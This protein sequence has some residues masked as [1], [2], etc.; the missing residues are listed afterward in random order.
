MKEYLSE[1]NYVHGTIG[2]YKGHRVRITPFCQPCIDAQKVYNR[3]YKQTHKEQTRKVAK[4][5]IR[6]LL[7]QKLLALNESNG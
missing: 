1:D 6:N 2:G 7:Y 4:Q 3:N 5:H